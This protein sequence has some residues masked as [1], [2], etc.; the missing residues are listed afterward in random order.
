MRL[1]LLPLYFTLL[2]TPSFPFLSFRFPPISFLPPFSPHFH[3]SLYFPSLSSSLFLLSLFF[4]LS[5]ILPTPFPFIPIFLLVPSLSSLLLP[6]P[7][8]LLPFLFSPSSLPSFSHYF[9]P[10][11]EG[12]KEEAGMKASSFLFSLYFPLFFLS[13]CPSVIIA[14]PFL[15]FLPSYLPTSAYPPLLPIFLPFAF[16]LHCL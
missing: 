16:L 1:F 12:R 2:L 5:F 3:S 8:F 7:S 14:F 15:F 4:P 11:K 10:R 6:F 13:S 9:L